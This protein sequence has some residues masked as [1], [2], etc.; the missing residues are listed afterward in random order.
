MGAQDRYCL[1]AKAFP[2]LRAD[3]NLQRLT[4]SIGKRLSN[5]KRDS[6]E[7]DMRKLRRRTKFFQGNGDAKPLSSK[8]DYLFYAVAFRGGERRAQALP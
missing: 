1:I 5:R 7:L 3:G 6:N 4:C 2:E 8:N